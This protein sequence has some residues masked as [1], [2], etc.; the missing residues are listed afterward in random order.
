MSLLSQVKNE[1]EMGLQ[2]VEPKRKQF[3]ERIRNETTKAK[4]K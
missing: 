1:Y 3:R 2:Y 4:V